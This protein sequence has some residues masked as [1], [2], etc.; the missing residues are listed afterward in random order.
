MRL[1]SSQ[2]RW[3]KAGIYGILLGMLALATPTFAQDGDIVFD[4][5][6]DKSI[7]SWKRA[8]GDVFSDD[9]PA[10][11][12]SEDLATGGYGGSLRINTAFKGG[13]W[14]EI[15]IGVWLSGRPWEK[16]DL[17]DID[18]IS[19]DLL[20]PAAMASGDALIK[21]STSL[22][23]EWAQVGPT[24]PDYPFATMERVVIG[25]KPFFKVTKSDPIGA[26]VNR[27][28][29][30]MLILRLAG[31]HVV[32]R[33]PIYYDNI[34]LRVKRNEIL[35]K[36]PRRYDA[37]S[38]IVPLQL[39][40]PA[41]GAG[42][43]VAYYAIDSGEMMP[44]DCSGDAICT[45]QWDSTT[46]PDGFHT[47]AFSY[48]HKR[49]G[50]DRTEARRL[51]IMVTNTPLALQIITP[52]EFQPLDARPVVRVR[53]TGAVPDKVVVTIAHSRE[54]PLLR[55]PDGDYEITL[56]QSTLSDGAHTLYVR[57]IWN[58]KMVEKSLDVIAAAHDDNALKFVERRG[59]DFAF[60]DPPWQGMERVHPVTFTGFNAYDLPFKKQ[61]LLNTNQ[62]GLVYDEFGRAL[63][64]L[65][66][67]GTTITYE[68]MVDR[69]MMEGRKRGMRVMRTWGINSDLTQDEFTFY[70]RDWSYNETEFA[71]FDYLLDSAARHGIRVIIVLQNNWSPYGGLLSIAKKFNL[72]SPLEFYENPDAQKMYQDYIEHFVSRTNTVSG[73]RYKDDPTIFAWELMNE[74]RMGLAEDSTPD[75]SLYDKDGTRLSTWIR[76]SAAFI[77]GLDPRHLVATGAEGH[78]YG[79]FGGTNEGYGADPLKVMDQPGVDFFTLHFYPNA[80]GTDFSLEHSKQFLCDFV[81]KG[82]AHQKPVVLEEWSINKQRPIAID[83]GAIA[84]TDP[85]YGA[86]KNRF[87]DEML[88]SFRACGGNASLFWMLQMNQQDAEYG[89]NVYTPADLV[90]HDQPLW[91]IFAP[92]G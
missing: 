46:V 15:N 48:V 85:R 56:D 47:I 81:A 53:V 54:F 64:Q 87:M 72:S 25:G 57:A 43:G 79:G 34:V 11:V 7:G 92:R 75:K 30:G 44:L 80:D 5:N 31:Y 45:A 36:R 60:V 37:V 61:N 39:K 83:G 65:L 4:F 18:T 1:W 69:L 59:S 62:K 12:Y 82:H 50:A 16:I 73:I 66:S 32:Y 13:S 70:N 42:D 41:E 26:D 6:Q 55:R 52:K 8:W 88:Q 33:G 84:P 22:D 27:T 40:I 90:E 86:A 14:E 35:P 3:G 2:N 78:G 77:K 68:N 91:Q 24:F 28:G 21:L 10:L 20:L 89:A 58:G 9:A 67:K 23:K 29:S 19:Y 38:G 63:P 51:E 74:P 17:T 76:L 71:R 49:N